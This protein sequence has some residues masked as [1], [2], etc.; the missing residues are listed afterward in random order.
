MKL[1]LSSGNLS[2]LGFFLCCALQQMK[3]LNSDC[4]MCLF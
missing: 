3:G 1:A 4:G 2:G